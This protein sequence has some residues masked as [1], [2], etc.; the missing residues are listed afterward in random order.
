MLFRDFWWFRSGLGESQVWTMAKKHEPL[1]SFN[2]LKQSS[3]SLLC[4]NP[5]VHRAIA[6]M[7]PRNGLASRVSTVFASIPPS[8]LAFQLRLTIS[9]PASSISSSKLW[10][11]SSNE[12][13]FV[14]YGQV[15]TES[16]YSKFITKATM[17]P[18]SSWNDQ[19][20]NKLKGHFFATW[21]LTAIAASMDTFLSS[22]TR[23]QW[24][25]G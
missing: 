16:F 14:L 2:P 17:S 13:H 9:S 6:I 21:F 15:F 25:F 3:S 23:N 12:Q 8:P 5:Q 19:F 22:I 20:P 18:S 1:P 10:L 7:S 24:V 11:Q 4:H